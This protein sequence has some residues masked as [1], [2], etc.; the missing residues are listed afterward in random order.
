MKPGY[1]FLFS[2]YITFVIYSLGTLVWGSAGILQTSQ[3]ENYKNR[4]ASNTIELGEIGSKLETQFNLLRLDED[5]I[6]VKARDL[7]YLSSNEGRIIIEGYN[8]GNRGFNVGSYYK[9]YNSPVSNSNK[10]RLFS[11][12]MGVFFFLILSIN[13]HHQ[14]WRL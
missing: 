9:R 1:R 2:I 11:L 14:K 5:L 4:L 10:I 13:N 6:A 12:L 8:P 7:G 3:L